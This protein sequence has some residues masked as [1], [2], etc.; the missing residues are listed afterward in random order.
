[1]HQPKYKI[2]IMWYIAYIANAVTIIF[3]WAYLYSSL[4][5]HFQNTIMAKWW[6]V[7]YIPISVLPFVVIFMFHR[8][9]VM[10]YF[11]FAKNSLTRGG[12]G[13]GVSANTP[14]NTLN[15]PALIKFTSPSGGEKKFLAPLKKRIGNAPLLKQSSSSSSSSNG[16]SKEDPPTTT[17]DP[18]S[19]TRLL[20]ENASIYRVAHL[21]MTVLTLI[22]L[23]VSLVF[24]AVDSSNCKPSSSDPSNLCNDKFFTTTLALCIVLIVLSLGHLVL[25]C[26]LENSLEWEE[27]EE[28]DFYSQNDEEGEELTAV[29]L[30]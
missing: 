24:L 19:Y 5:L 25:G 1:M 17:T 22:L 20:V 6:L 27:D 14:T 7:V 23:I 26:F 13:G 21:S 28:V 29:K 12:G 9:Q 4:Q 8:L 18:Y 11:V 30:T 15:K 2:G 3:W 10:D 16:T